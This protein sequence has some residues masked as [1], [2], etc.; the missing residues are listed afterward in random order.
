MFILTAILL[1]I[2]HL[3]KKDNDILQQYLEKLQQKFD[4][5]Q[6]WKQLID[7]LQEGIILIDKDFQ[8]KYQNRTID[9]IFGLPQQ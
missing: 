7:D 2:L 3:Y 8:I 4:E 5:E 1:L 6:S 9:T